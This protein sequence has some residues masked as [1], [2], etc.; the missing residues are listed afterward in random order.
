MRQVST[1]IQTATATAP[2]PPAKISQ[3]AIHSVA[4]LSVQIAVLCCSVGNSFL[5]A[6]MGGPEGKGIL[7]SLQ[8]ISSVLGLSLMHF[9]LGSA[10]IVLLKQQRNSS[11]ELAGGVFLPSILLGLLPAAALALAWHWLSGTGITHMNPLF[12]WLAMLALPAMVLTYNVSFFCLA[13]DRLARY[14][15]LTAASPVV[16]AVGLCSFMLLGKT[17]IAYLIAAWLFST[18]VPAI[19]A[20]YVIV[21]AAKGSLLP[22]IPLLKKMYE[23]GWRAHLCGVLQQLQ[24]RSPVLLVATYLPVAQLGIYSL[25]IGLIELLWY[26][27]NTLSVALLPH[28]AG[29][30]RE[31]ASRVTPVICRVTLAV[32]SLLGILLLLFCS[33]VIPWVLPRFTASL[34][35]LWLLLPGVVVSS[36]SRVIAS[37]LNGRG[38]PMK[39][40]APVFYSLLIETALGVYFIPRYGL[41]AAA[42]VTVTGYFV[43]TAVQIPIYCQIANVPA[44][45]IL[46]IHKQDI[47]AIIRLVRSRIEKLRELISPEFAT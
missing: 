31:N 24:H 47:A 15:W 14:N 25:S 20:A 9:C 23:F 19:F 44:S 46:I 30:S 8:L 45:S 32:T 28:I 3:L 21:S 42:L 43:N 5:T 39:A 18:F 41:R 35:P 6:R 2:P 7:Y 17:T 34:L 26:I 13:D 37:D 38:I 1:G 29:S 4:I 12:L 11:S 33:V 36:I 16:L 27:P 40:F 22:S 10:A